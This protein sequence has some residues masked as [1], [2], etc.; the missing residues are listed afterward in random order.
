[1]LSTGL[2]H[3]FIL[4]FFSL[5]Q[6]WTSYVCPLVEIIYM[7]KNYMTILVHFS[8]SHKGISKCSTRGHHN[9]FIVEQSSKDNI[10]SRPNLSPCVKSLFIQG[11]L[12]GCS[13][14]IPST[15]VCRGVALPS[16]SP[17]LIITVTLDSCCSVFCSFL[18]AGD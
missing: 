9:A 3:T 15:P 14:N 13:V 17:P 2:E 12:T 1:M 18:T 16:F 4:C 7:I 6:S 10:N 11:W 8:T 5:Q